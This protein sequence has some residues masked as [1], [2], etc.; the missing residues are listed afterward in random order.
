MGLEGLLVG[1]QVMRL[2]FYEIFSRCYDGDGKPFTP[3][4]VS[5][6]ELNEAQPAQAEASV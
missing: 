3:I 4:S 6:D 1:I 5:F 2:E